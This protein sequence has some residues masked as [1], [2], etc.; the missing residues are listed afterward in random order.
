MPQALVLTLP[1]FLNACQQFASAN[2]KLSSLLFTSTSVYDRKVLRTTKFSHVD[3]TTK[4]GQRSDFTDNS[5]PFIFFKGL[6]SGWK[7]LLFSQK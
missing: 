4:G 6:H 1:Y 2:Q 5:I 3:E 7:P